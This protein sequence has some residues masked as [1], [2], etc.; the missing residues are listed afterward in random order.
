[1]EKKDRILAA[2]VVND[3]IAQASVANVPAKVSA[4]VVLGGISKEHLTRLFAKYSSIIREHL[5]SA[6]DE[7]R[8]TK[9]FDTYRYTSKHQS[10][11]ILTTD[12]CNKHYNLPHDL[13]KRYAGA[14]GV[15]VFIAEEIRANSDLTSDTT[16]SSFSDDY[17]KLVIA[18]TSDLPLYYGINQLPT[19]IYTDPLYIFTDGAS[20]TK[21]PHATGWA[22]YF[23]R[24]STKTMIYSAMA[25]QEDDNGAITKKTNNQA[26]GLA[27]VTA[28]KYLHDNDICY[29]VVLVSDS[30]LYINIITSY[31]HT[32]Y[33]QDKEFRGNTTA[34]TPVKNRKII[35]DLYKYYTSCIKKNP[36]LTIKHIASHRSP[37]FDLNSLEYRLYM[38]NKLADEYACAAKSLPDFEPRVQNMFERHK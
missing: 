27:I 37:P 15:L 32:W 8:I 1:M 38:G 31:M 20:N 28:L 23:D 25:P 34:K 18:I 29:P 14:Q 13:V 22:V 2:P 11:L 36:H 26:E 24:T 4:T 3:H 6:T 10:A 17:S 30:M 7:K 12:E 21:P 5:A 9:I 35:V 19:H 16:I 33:L